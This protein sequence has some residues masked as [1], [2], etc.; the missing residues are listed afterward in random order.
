MAIL[1]VI[2]LMLNTIEEEKKRSHRSSKS[3]SERGFESR[4]DCDI[5]GRP[6]SGMKSDE[7]FNL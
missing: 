3:K 7:D 6:V 4:N 5:R 1:F 2:L